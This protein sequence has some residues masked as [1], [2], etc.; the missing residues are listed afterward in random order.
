[1]TMVDK[2]SNRE[3][4]V[5]FVME[6]YSVDRETAVELYQNEI[7]NYIWLLERRDAFSKPS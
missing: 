1:M 6:F 4:A 3:Q 7:E 5:Q 2:N